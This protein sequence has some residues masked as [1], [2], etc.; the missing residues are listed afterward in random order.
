[1]KEKLIS[2]RKKLANF[3]LPILVLPYGDKIV[4]AIG[5]ALIVT[6]LELNS[7]IWGYLFVG[8]FIATVWELLWN[9]ID[10]EKYHIDQLD[11]LATTLGAFVMGFIMNT[12]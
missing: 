10:K 7:N 2:F 11:I 9:N 1:M 6:L 12:I 4:H 5:G 3:F 8:F